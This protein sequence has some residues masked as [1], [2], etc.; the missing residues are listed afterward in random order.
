[1]SDSIPLLPF[2]LFS[3]NV[4][5]CAGRATAVAG[6]SGLLALAFCN[7]MFEQRWEIVVKSC[8]PV[9]YLLSGLVFRAPLFPLKCQ[10][11]NLTCV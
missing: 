3:S 11:S 8:L 10:A 1:M 7:V 4:C 5:L 2:P 6:S 9:A